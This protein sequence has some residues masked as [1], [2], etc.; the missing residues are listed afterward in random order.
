MNASVVLT[1]P[2]GKNEALARRLAATGLQ[3]LLLPA[4][5][6]RPLAHDPGSIPPPA[7]YDLIVFVSGH[8]LRLYLD[9]LSEHTR[10]SG[11]PAHTLAA[12]VGAASARLLEDAPYVRPGQIIYPGPDDS[13]DSEGLWRLLEPRLGTIK[14]VLIARGGTGREWLGT[15]LQ[16]AGLQ[17]RRLALY[18]RIPAQWD[19]AQTG[20]LEQALRAGSPCVFLLTS[21][22]SVDAVHANIR[23]LGLED[24]WGRS[25]F[26]VIH[27]RVACR[28]QSLLKAS[29]KVEP[30][31][32]KICQPGDDAIFQTIALAASLSASS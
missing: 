7:E 25:R 27:E 22:E 20:Q 29:G 16:E 21:S 12:T 32:V 9:T 14:R 28:L 8:A 15:K 30:P 3:T 13:Q 2:Q 1:R 31:V 23:R 18:E 26:V 6:I 24:A 19:T 10:S 11:W 4:L 5:H 17:V